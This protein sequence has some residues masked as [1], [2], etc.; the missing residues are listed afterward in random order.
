MFDAHANFSYS[1]VA[2][3]PTPASSGT[4]LTVR[5]GDGTLY[6][7]APFN[8]VVW[9]AFT[10]PLASNATIIRVTNISTDTFTFTRS[11]EG[12]SNRS[13]RIGDQIAVPVT[14]KTLTDIE[15][16]LTTLSANI[17][18]VDASAVHITGNE[19]ISGIKTFIS[20]PLVPTAS[21][22]DNSLKAA[23]TAY[24][25]AAAIAA[26]IGG[27]PDATTI[28]K[29]KLQLA[30]DL[31]GVNSTADSP[32]I[33]NVAKLFNVKDYGA[34]GNG[35]TNDA[36]AIANTIT[37]ANIVGGTVFFPDG[38]FIVNSALNVN[39]S[40]VTF[41]GYGIGR[42]ILKAG[43]AFTNGILTLNG[44]SPVLK[45]IVIQD[46]EFDSN[47]LS[48]VLGIS[49]KGGAFASGQ[50]AAGIRIR[51]CA[52]RNLSTI[53]VGLVQIY[54]GRGTTDRGFVTDLIIEDSDFYDTAKYHVYLQGG[55][56]E[57]FK[58]RRNR[59]FNSQGGC[60][61][62]NAQTRSGSSVASYRS[63]KNW[64]ISDNYFSNNMLGAFQLGLIQDVNRTGVRNLRILNNFFDGQVT[65]QQQYCINVHSGWALE[66]S[67]NTFWNTRTVM[68]IG[69]SANGDF[70]KI[71][72]DNMAR[73]N[74]NFFYKTF[75]IA[76][77][78]ASFFAMWRGN[79]FYETVTS[80][81]GGFSRHFPS[82][83]I[84]NF[85]YNSP[86]DGTGAAT[87]KA[88]F[89]VTPDGV[90][91]RGNT[92]VDDRLVANPTTAPVLTT[93]AGG[94]LGSRTYF[95]KY[96][97]VNDTGETLAS[98]ESTI[99][100]PTNS[101]LVATIPYST[102]YG[103]PT[104]AKKVNW[105]V[106][107]TTNAETL[108][109]FTPT[110][111]TTEI[112][113]DHTINSTM[114][115]TEPTTGLVAG[116]ALPSTNTTSALTLYGIYEVS[117][118]VSGKSNIY[119]NNKFYGI[120]T[121]I[122]KV[123]TYKRVTFNNVSTPDLTTNVSQLLENTT[124]AQ[125]NITGATTID[126]GNSGLISATLTGPTTLTLS[127]GHYTGQT[128]TIVFTQDATG[129]RVITWPGNAVFNSAGSMVLSTTAGV[130]DLIS[131]YY[132]G[133]NWRESYRSTG[134]LNTTISGVLKGN[135]STIVAATAGTDYTTPSST[136][137]VTNK[138]LTSGTNTFP[139]FNQNTTGTASNVTG[140]VAIANGGTGSATQNFVDL[141]TTQ[142]AAGN[143]TFS[144]ATTLTGAVALGTAGYRSN[145]A[146]RTANVTL[147]AT[148]A[149]NQ[150][151]DATSGAFAVTL[152]PANAAAG[153]MI[154]VK[155][156]D[157]SANAVT[158]TRA[159]TDTIDGATTYVLAAQYKSV[160][161][162][163]NNGTQ[164]FVI[165]VV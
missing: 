69:S 161:L 80:G 76:D 148:S 150:L 45:N 130:T 52:F 154:T 158:V 25:D 141:T 104:G 51:R 14:K 6:P 146:M 83:Y 66:I 92:V 8:A 111:W 131:F 63:N 78:D 33:R 122:S 81:L 110:A 101:R 79:V 47:N 140:I 9:P 132:D 93:T 135:G 10:I 22:L 137:T 139:T 34:L 30:G 61:A 72:G 36:T 59:F 2:T 74:E 118:A 65:T 84:D 115:F 7:T 99:A 77:H 144:G 71:I 152:P 153:Q 1:V 155:K 49:I 142:S 119:E 73:I 96:T 94:S 32:Q 100:V 19:N 121:P 95:V 67:K 11:Q 87:T 24:A 48:G 128:L 62:F 29:G 31:G 40:N 91:V 120:A 102:S 143:K 114:A 129:S 151:C 138:N 147:A 46:I 38:I 106:S 58:I 21:P 57:Q 107:T 43:A 13:I 134:V 18:S 164:W 75:N 133:T 23:S 149:L 109:D 103:V 89:N 68:A 145:P 35:S 108:Q 136:E 126:V 37:A 70:Y 12:S 27:T 4:S 5:A 160:T 85:F 124:F 123:S 162:L 156:I 97:Y 159:G 15:S 86:T 165:G 55:N 157:V 41:Q 20:S 28:S 90:V 163:S 127:P 64:E 39:A 60:I 82:Q 17:G 116:T 16:Y 98:N 42:S 125:G 44:L 54:A 50:S 105:Y 113:T 88:A 3:A 112:E 56:V 26:S 53:D 117:G